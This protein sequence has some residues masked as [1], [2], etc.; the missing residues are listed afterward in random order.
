MKALFG[1]VSLLIALA[2]VGVLA[3]RQFKATAQVTTPTS[4]NATTPSTVKQQST[5]VQEQVR[6]DI[7]KAVEQSTRKIDADQ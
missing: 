3:S 2:L 1:G 4:S 5:L 6:N 7:A